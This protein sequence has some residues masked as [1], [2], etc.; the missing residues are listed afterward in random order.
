MN[1]S[2]SVFSFANRE[3]LSLVSSANAP[4]LFAPPATLTTADVLLHA[5]AKRRFVRAVQALRR[6]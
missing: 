4:V 3:H 6:R 2:T 5:A 1:S